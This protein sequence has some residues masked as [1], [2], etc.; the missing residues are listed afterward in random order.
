M[1]KIKKIKTVSLIASAA[2]LAQSGAALASGA[3][4]SDTQGTW[5]E[6]PVELV[7]SLNIIDGY[8]DDLF[9]P[10]DNVTLAQLSAM[11]CRVERGITGEETSAS[12]YS[13]YWGTACI[14]W[15]DS[16]KL[17]D[18]FVNIDGTEAAEVAAE[19]GDVNLTREQV[20]SMLYRYYL[21]GGGAQTAD[22]KMTKAFNDTEGIS[23]YALPAVSWAA[24]NGIIEGD[25]D[26]MF[27]PQADVTRAETA[28]IMERY[29]TGFTDLSGSAEQPEA[30]PE[31]D[32]AEPDEAE[33]A[34]G[35][36]EQSAEIVNPII[37]YG[38]K[39]P[40]TETLTFP[41]I[42]LTGLE[43]TDYSTINEA[44]P[45]KAIIEGRGTYDG[46]A[47]T[48]RIG[49]GDRDISGI[50][51]GEDVED[52][53]AELSVSYMR[54]DSTVYAVWAVTD[55]DRRITCYSAAI[56]DGTIEQLIRIVDAIG[57][58]QIID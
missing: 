2:L 1:K 29:I 16:K 46:N 23:A 6:E 54:F 21:A 14:V 48:I 18:G 5:F 52:A 53:P 40:E 13:G 12:E 31:P 32:K 28:A 57:A 51:G 22:D 26:M 58:E 3:S 38:D 17:F 27:N 37:E 42:T 11:L 50:Y 30:S 24:A 34:P 25:D 49:M 10:Y 47:V 55:D 41:V 33:T 20:V 19:I 8:E 9:H 56:K 4:F 7:H 39:A 45:D 44:D 35:G 36:A 15:A 43:L